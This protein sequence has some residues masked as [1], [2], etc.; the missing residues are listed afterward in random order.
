MNLDSK[1]IMKTALDQCDAINLLVDAQ[2]NLIEALHIM[3]SAVEYNDNID[4]K[5]INERRMMKFISK[6]E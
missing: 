1:K 2:Q 3:D 4:D 5:E 6:F